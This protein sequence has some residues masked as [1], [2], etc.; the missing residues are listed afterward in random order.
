M[1]TVK[2]ALIQAQPI[3]YDLPKTVD[4]AISLIQTASQQGAKLVAFGETW[5]AG[6]P[7]WLDTARNVAVWD[8]PI[9]K[10][11][12]ARLHANS[13]S[14][15]SPEMETLKSTA[16]ENELVLVLSINEKVAGHGTLYNSL[17]TIDATGEIVN[18][19]RKLMPTYTERL[20][21]GMGDGNG[22][23][24]VDTKVGR[25]GGLI[26]WEHWMPLARQA[27][28][29]SGEQIHVA[30]WPT[31]GEM[32]QIASRHYAFEGRTYVLA[33][34]SLLQADALPDEL[35]LIE[36]IQPDTLIQQGGSAVIAT[37]GQYLIEPIFDEETI[38]TCEL[39]LDAIPKEQLT[40][41]VA[42]HYARPDVFNF[43]VN[44][45]HD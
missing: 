30:V 12:F 43:S 38:L 26:C 45:N 2:V 44:S 16:R 9:V 32:H 37:N 36:G 21:W 23:Q 27:M 22:L 13:L 15:D 11:L 4:K 14:L 1:T 28:H 20:I 18:H 31:V 3:Y 17:I 7:K 5:F 42:G 24:A 41:D 34:G 6:Y 29:N 40:L 10:D 35:E 25:V 39:D 19:H 33:V 8:N